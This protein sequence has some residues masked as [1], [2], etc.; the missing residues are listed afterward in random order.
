M[1]KKVLKVSVAASLA[2]GSIAGIPMSTPA[3]QQLF[4]TTT[5]H[6]SLAAYP[7]LPVETNAWVQR[8]INVYSKLTVEEMQS[9][10]DFQKALSQLT[11]SGNDALVAPIVNHLN[12]KKTSNLLTTA[13]VLQV[14][15]F[16]GT[17]ASTDDAD[18][19]SKHLNAFRSDALVRGAISKVLDGTPVS[20]DGQNQIQFADITAFHDAVHNALLK[21]I[22][23]TKAMIYIDAQKKGKLA[24]Q[25]ASI[26][27]DM[28]AAYLEVLGN[29]NLKLSQAMAHYGSTT[30]ARAELAEAIATSYLN[31]V[32]SVDTDMD[33][34]IAI[35]KAL[36]RSEASLTS[37]SGTT[38]LTPVLKLFGNDISSLVTWKSS[39]ELISFSNGKFVLS[40]GAADNTTIT[41]EVSAHDAAFNELVFKGTITLR[42]NVESPSSGPGGGPPGP[43]PT[44]VKPPADRAEQAEAANKAVNEAKEKAQNARPLERAAIVKEAVQE[45]KEAVKNMSKVTISSDN[46]TVIDGK[47]V[48]VFNEGDV[49]NQ[50]KE[51]KLQVNKLQSGIKEIAPKAQVPFEFTLDFGTIEAKTLS[52]PLSGE[53]LNG[54]KDN[55]VTKLNVEANG[56]GV[57]FKPEQFKDD[58]TLTIEKV[59]QDTISSLLSRTTVSPIVDVTFHSSNGTEINNFATPVDLRLNIP[60]HPEPDYLSIFK[61]EVDNRLTNYGGMFIDGGVKTQRITLS[62]YVVLEN[63]VEFGDTS[64]VSSWAGKEI[65]FIATKGIAE[66]RA[67]GQFDPSANVTRAEFAKMLANALGIVGGHATETFSDVT[68]QDWHQP[69]VAAVQQRGIVNGRADGRFDP[70]AVITRAE[71]ATMIA[72][73]LKAIH[74]TDN[75][76]EAKEMLAQFTDHELIHASLQE[77]VALAAEQSIIQG[78]PTG[79]FAPNQSTTRAQAAVMIY[80][81]LK[82]Q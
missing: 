58:T 71:M 10:K 23:L 60:T 30:T 12:S 18:L 55:G 62:P 38:E 5:A 28:K 43:P 24:E 7:P 56:T 52:I 61:V 46:V 17:V 34:Q 74:G 50:I 82:L 19:L 1:K 77:G 22:T 33:A 4:G 51:I 40:S 26:K 21:Q 25:K 14:L 8:I 2:L 36:L 49:I 45:I 66:G 32:D 64:S 68:D 37:T 75:L 29:Q 15:G 57:G 76:F 27:A 39:N 11:P 20:L 78:L 81:L 13:D 63:K 73:G 69:Y 35:V 9:V 53:V 44:T 16:F 48:P 6:A 70:N 31:V 59:P 3:V 41:A 80:R 47:T 42:R 72:R 54:A 67:E 79:E 65:R